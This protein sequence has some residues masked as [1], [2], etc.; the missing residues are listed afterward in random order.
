MK[1]QNEAE[2]EMPITLSYL[3]SAGKTE[4]KKLRGTFPLFNKIQAEA[5]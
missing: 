5:L 4:N 2:L 1:T 3:T